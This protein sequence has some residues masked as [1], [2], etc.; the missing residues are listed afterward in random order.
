M[1]ALSLKKKGILYHPFVCVSLSYLFFC[2]DLSL[3]LILAILILKKQYKKGK[4]NKMYKNNKIINI[5]K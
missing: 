2:L 4:I 1:T 3:I 5:K